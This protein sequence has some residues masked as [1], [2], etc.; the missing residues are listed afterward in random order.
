M[1]WFLEMTSEARLCIDERVL[2]WDGLGEINK[3]DHD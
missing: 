2:I 1:D 3:N